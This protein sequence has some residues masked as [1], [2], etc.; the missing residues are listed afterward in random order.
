MLIG[1]ERE[2][3]FVADTMY[4]Q[5]LRT[6]KK[7]H[8]HIRRCNAV[9]QLHIRMKMRHKQHIIIY[10]FVLEKFNARKKLLQR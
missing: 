2:A 4:L 8:I 9:T 10:I 3:Y 5:I 7:P 1:K 6:Y